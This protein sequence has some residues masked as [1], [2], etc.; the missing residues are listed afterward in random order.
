MKDESSG[1]Q[2]FLRSVYVKAS[3]LEYD[4]L[5]RERVQLNRQRLRRQSLRRI[6]IVLLGLVISIAIL[7]Y[8]SLDLGTLV[9]LSCAIIALGTVLEYDGMRW[10]EGEPPNTKKG[11][12]NWK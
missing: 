1:N 3:L 4:R 8:Y 5:E 6:A 12:T 11:W 9:T 7:R 2:A 10:S